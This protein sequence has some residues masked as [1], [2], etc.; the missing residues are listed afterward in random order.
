MPSARKPRRPGRRARRTRSRC[1][2][3]VRSRP[4]ERRP[5]RSRSAR[6]PRSPRWPGR[7]ARR[8]RA[9]SPPPGSGRPRACPPAGSAPRG[10][11]RRPASAESTRGTITPAAPASSAAA[12]SA[13]AFPLTRTSA[14]VPERVDAATRLCTVSR[15]IAECSAS[16]HRKSRP[17]RP[18]TS[19]V[20]ALGVWTNVPTSGSP[21]SRR[22]RT[23]RRVRPSGGVRGTRA[24]SRR[25]RADAGRPR[26]RGARPGRSPPRGRGSAPA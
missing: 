25:T 21:W 7:G 26:S 8:Q 11:P 13:G 3:R 12:I 23:P 24:R 15:P 10:P 16:T 20:T 5:A 1:R 2:R 9:R 17:S 6:R 18:T 19:A 22:A 4:P 14:G